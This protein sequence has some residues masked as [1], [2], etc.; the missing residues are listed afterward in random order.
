MFVQTSTIYVVVITQ[1]VILVCPHQWGTTN[2][3]RDITAVCAAPC[4]LFA[5]CFEVLQIFEAVP[6]TFD[7]IDLVVLVFFAFLEGRMFKRLI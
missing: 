3:V 4:C 1:F 2:V 7:V 6:G 5:F